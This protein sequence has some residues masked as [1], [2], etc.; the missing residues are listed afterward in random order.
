MMENVEFQHYSAVL[1]E[2]FTVNM[3]YFNQK[4][5]WRYIYTLEKIAVHHNHLQKLIKI[6]VQ[7]CYY[8]LVRRYHWGNWGK[9]TWDLSVLVLNSCMWI[10]NNPN[11]NFK[12]KKKT[13][14]EKIQNKQKS[15]ALNAMWYL[16]VKRSKGRKRRILWKLVKLE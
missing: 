6:Q 8:W 14:P 13:K 4:N 9:S 2:F 3:S 7:Y 16:G 15:S 1:F 5:Q 12:R 10:Y 11:K